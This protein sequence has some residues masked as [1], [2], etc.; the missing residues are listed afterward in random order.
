MKSSSELLFFLA[1]DF[2]CCAGADCVLVSP[3]PDGAPAPAATATLGATISAAAIDVTAIDM[4]ASEPSTRTGVGVM[5]T[6]FMT[7]LR[8]VRTS[9][10]G[11]KLLRQLCV[12]LE[13]ASG[14]A[15]EGPPV[16]V[17]H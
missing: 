9:L 5:S 14:S 15:S 10:R 1:C 6:F 11:F 3:P 17:E 13:R 8:E 2:F 7:L 4:A 12:P 16:P